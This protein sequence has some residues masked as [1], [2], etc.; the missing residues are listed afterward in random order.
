M[1]LGNRFPST[2]VFT[3]GGSNDS[4]NPRTRPAREIPI[5]KSWSDLFRDDSLADRVR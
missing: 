5:L 1:L 3:L 4:R 2:F